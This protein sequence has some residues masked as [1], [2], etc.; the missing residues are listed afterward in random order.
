MLERTNAAW[1]R[2]DKEK[3]KQRARDILYWPNMNAQIRDLIANCSSCL[4]QRKNNIKAH[5][6]PGKRL[7]VIYSPLVKRTIL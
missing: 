6:G 1:E 5:I 2:A 3:S 4:K 7:P